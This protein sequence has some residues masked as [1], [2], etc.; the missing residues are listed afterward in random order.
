MGGFFSILPRFSPVLYDF[1]RFF[2]NSRRSVEIEGCHPPANT[3]ERPTGI[4]N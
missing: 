1:L 2:A 3:F 4:S